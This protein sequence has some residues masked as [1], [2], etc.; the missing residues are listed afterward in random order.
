MGIF[1]R[2]QEIKKTRTRPRKRPR[3]QENKNSTKKA[4]EKTRKQELDQEKRKLLCR[5]RR[6]T[7]AYYLHGDII[8]AQS[9]L[10]IHKRKKESEQENNHASVH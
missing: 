1:K 6:G 7:G 10:G 9:G 4:I 5:R 3:K 8:L 2:K